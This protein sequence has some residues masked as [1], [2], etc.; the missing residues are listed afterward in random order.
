M[1]TFTISKASE[2]SADHAADFTVTSSD[3]AAQWPQALRHALLTKC[4]GIA[5]T[6]VGVVTSAGRARHEFS[7]LTGVDASVPDLMLS[8][9]NVRFALPPTQ[10]E[11]LITLNAVGPRVVTSTD[12]T[13]AGVEVLTGRGAVH[14][15]PGCQRDL[16]GAAAARPRLLAGQ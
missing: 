5:A 15:R 4:E 9:G 14:G 13:Q 10:T 3:Q 6:A 2:P 12:L 16:R 7:E 1:P 11:Q 8:L